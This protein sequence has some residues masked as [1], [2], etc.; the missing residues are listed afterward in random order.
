MAVTLI[1]VISFYYSDLYAIDQTLSIRELSLCLMSG[2]GFACIL[3]A[4]FSYPTPRF[5]KTLY[6]S[7]MAMMVISLCGWRV[8]FKRVIA[9]ARG[10]THGSWWL[11]YR[12]R[13]TSG[14]RTPETKETRDGG[15]WLCGPEP[16][17]RQLTLAYGNRIRVSLPIYQPSSLM[18]L[19]QS[20]N[21]NRILLAGVEGYHDCAGARTSQFACPWRGDGRLPLFL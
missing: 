17:C 7:Q 6:A 9:R 20:Q 2:V 14:G 12:H 15:D 8:G 18:A 5:G 10:F 11:D 21:V 1:V 13:Q 4:F 19:F 16:I 3:I